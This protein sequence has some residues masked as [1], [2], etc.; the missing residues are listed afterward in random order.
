VFERGAAHRPYF[1]NRDVA[2]GSTT[3]C[4]LLDR[5]GHRGHA[6]NL[7]PGPAAREKVEIDK[8]Y[9]TEALEPARTRSAWHS[10]SRASS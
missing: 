5:G 10:G 2:P 4:S 6:R 1:V 3:T 7:H 9:T 8:S